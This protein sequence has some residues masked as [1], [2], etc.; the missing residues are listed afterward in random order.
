MI[1]YG[2]QE[3]TQDDLDEVVRVLK[4]DYLTQGPEIGNFE[5][6]FAAYVGS[7][8]AVACSNGTAAL[9]LACLALGVAPGHKVITTPMTFAGSANCVRYC[10]GEV[11]FAEID[12]SS[13]NLCPQQVEALL[14]KSPA[15][16]Y[17]GLIVVDYAGFP[18]DLPA[19]RKLADR[20][21]LWVIE[22]ACH[23][24]GAGRADFRCG[25][26]QFSDLTCFS[27][28]PVK[29]IAAGEGGA[30]TTRSRDLYERCSL[31]RTHGITRDPSLLQENH[32][33]W[34][35]EMV[36]LGFNYRLT[37]FQAALAS[38]QLRRADENLKRRNQLAERYRAAF[39]DSP[40]ELVAV[41]PGIEHAYHLYVVRVDDRLGLYNRLRERDILAQV[42]YIPVHTFPAYQSLGW[43]KGDFPLAEDWYSRCL[44]LPLYPTL[45]DEQ[46]DFVIEAVL[47]FVDNR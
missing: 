46:Q 30:I 45:T 20:Y 27:F 7:E 26:G 17:Q 13:G 47:E 18:A 6:A 14:E 34:Y 33:G 31:L 19:F 15:G 2:R 10:G 41:A 11:V 22:D 24:P 43:K 9:H 12:P 25:D 44:S 1:P 39:Q 35:Y 3:I 23:A 4:S 21:G 38:S 37:D 32:G 42:H 8:Y 5:R 40:L 16:T 29:H 36:D 28:H